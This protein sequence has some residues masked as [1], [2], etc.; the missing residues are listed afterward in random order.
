MKIK[1]FLILTEGSSDV[2]SIKDYIKINFNKLLQKKLKGSY[3]FYRKFGDEIPIKF[4]IKRD[5]SLNDMEEINIVLPVFEVTKNKEQKIN[6]YIKNSQNPNLKD[7]IKNMKDFSPKKMYGLE[8]VFQVYSVF[9]G[10]LGST[11]ESQINQYF[12][13]ED[14]NSILNFPSLESLYF[15]KN[16]QELFSNKELIYKL[17]TEIKNLIQFEE[18]SIFVFL[19]NNESNSQY[20]KKYSKELKYKSSN[21]FGDSF[22]YFQNNL[23]ED[24][25]SWG[26]LENMSKIYKEK[27]LC[28]K[29]HLIISFIP[30]VLENIIDLIIDRED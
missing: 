26:I 11:T 5:I 23:D 3:E 25:E 20:I 7:F 27:I 9:D 21:S 28:Q 19:K 6:I 18:N 4:S 22:Q 16:Y 2:L 10:D 29:R 14:I 15:Q 8:N 12:Q 30:I 17:D 24:Y 13:L 1:N